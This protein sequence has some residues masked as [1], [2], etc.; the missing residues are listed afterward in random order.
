MR[1]WEDMLNT[2][3]VYPYFIAQGVLIQDLLLE[4]TITGRV[5]MDGGK[6]QAESLQTAQ[7]SGLLDH[8]SMLNLERPLTLYEYLERRDVPYFN[9]EDEKAVKDTLTHEVGY[10]EYDWLLSL[11]GRD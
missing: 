11:K 1:S 10:A 7:E 2:I 6:I 4:D 9:M 3:H 5:H 8:A